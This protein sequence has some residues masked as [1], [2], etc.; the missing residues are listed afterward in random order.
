MPHRSQDNA[1]WFLNLE[2]NRDPPALEW[3]QQ[4]GTNLTLAEASEKLREGFRPAC[5][6]LLAPPGNLYRSAMAALRKAGN[7]VPIASLAFWSDEAE[8]KEWFNLEL[9]SAIHSQREQKAQRPNLYGLSNREIEILRLMVKGLIKKEIA[10]ELSVSYHTVD[11]HQRH[12]F[13]KLNVH[14]RS[15]AVAKAIMEK[16]Y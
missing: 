4:T 3:L 12:I 1:V 13:H 7:N 5:I 8:V 11:N 2:P 9:L 14:T 16:L 10:T 15:A 6:I